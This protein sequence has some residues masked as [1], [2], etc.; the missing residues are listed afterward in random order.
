[1][2]AFTTA[3]NSGNSILPRVKVVGPPGDSPTLPFLPSPKHQIPFLKDVIEKCRFE[4]RIRKKAITYV[5]KKNMEYQRNAPGSAPP[6]PGLWSSPSNPSVSR[7]MTMKFVWLICRLY[8]RHCRYFPLALLNSSRFSVF[9]FA[10]M[11]FRCLSVSGFW[12][13]MSVCAQADIHVC[14]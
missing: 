12:M 3:N 10:N 6:Y 1:M 14:T 13:R 2:I 9:E 5:K 11:G 7:N 4:N 8:H